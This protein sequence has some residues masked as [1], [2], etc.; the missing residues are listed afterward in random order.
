L[1]ILLSFS[2]SLHAISTFQQLRKPD[3]FPQSQL[4]PSKKAPSLPMVASPQ[5]NPDL[6]N[7][8]L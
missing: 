7:Q 4:N 3:F 1:T 2:A 8:L 6:V 5:P